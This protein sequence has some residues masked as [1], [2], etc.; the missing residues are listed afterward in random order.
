LALYFS[1]RKQEAL[2]A[3]QRAHKAR[4]GWPL[5]LET[6]AICHAALGQMSEARGCLDQMR[7]LPAPKGDPT[8]IMKRRNPE[9]SEE[10][11]A[12]LRKAI[13]HPRLSVVG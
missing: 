6:A 7:Q 11:D 8:E 1:G 13:A 9:W 4:P 3:A 12:Q 2:I 10:I 5:T